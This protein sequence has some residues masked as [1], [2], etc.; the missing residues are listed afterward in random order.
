MNK[1]KHY[2]EINEIGK[3]LLNMLK[4]EKFL[5]MLNNCSD[6]SQSFKSGAQYGVATAFSWICVKCPHYVEGK[7][8]EKE[9]E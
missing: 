6:T 4:S 9:E 5:E 1:E 7:K 2:L 3:E 8:E